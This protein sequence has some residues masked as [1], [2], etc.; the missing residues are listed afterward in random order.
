MPARQSAVMC[1][2]RPSLSLEPAAELEW[3]FDR[4]RCVIPHRQ[5]S[6]VGGRRCE[7]ENET[8]YVVEHGR[9]HSAVRA[10]GRTLERGTECDTYDDFVLREPDVQLRRGRIRRAGDGTVGHDVAARTRFGV[11]DHR[12]HAE[13]ASHMRSQQCRAVPSCAF[14]KVGDRGAG[15]A[16]DSVEQRGVGLVGDERM[17]Q[18]SERGGR[19]GRL[20]LT[21]V[22]DRS[23][24]QPAAVLRTRRWRRGPGPEGG[25]VSSAL[26]FR[27][28]EAT[29]PA[30]RPARRR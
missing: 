13:H 17:I 28:T 4:H 10:A 16:R 21:W 5:L 24:T 15:K 27:L 6:G 2:L 7:S 23:E 8:R 26:L 12:P 14:S 30:P 20:S 22:T 18:R 29:G 19:R 1:N 9:D 3:R 11:L 25:V